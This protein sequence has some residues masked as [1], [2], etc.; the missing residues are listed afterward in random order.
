MIFLNSAS[1]AAALVFYHLPGVCLH[2][3]TSREIRERPES[4][5]FGKNTI[6]NE[7]PVHK[8]YVEI[9]VVAESTK[10]ATY[11]IQ[12]TKHTIIIV[13]GGI[14]LWPLIIILLEMHKRFVLTFTA[15]S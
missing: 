15:N 14:F 8:N 5:I 9:T 2:T 4:G 13:F 3:L 11:T 12:Q 7:H 10:K 6:F 1:F